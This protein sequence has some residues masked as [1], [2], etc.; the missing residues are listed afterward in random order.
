M[1]ISNQ[2]L[3][4]KN[5]TIPVRAENESDF[6]STAID[7]LHPAAGVMALSPFCVNDD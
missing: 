1:G 2:D 7:E 3:N 4:I 6:W 5:E